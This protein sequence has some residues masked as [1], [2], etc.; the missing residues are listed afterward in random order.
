[1]KLNIITITVFT[2]SLMLGC[3][4]DKNKSDAYGNFEATETLIS[5]EVAG[6]IIKLD[7]EEGKMI[8]AGEVIAIIDTTQLYLKRQQLEAQRNAISAKTGNIAGQIKVYDEQK[9]NLLK[10]K[11][12]IEKMLKDG[13]ATQKQMDDVNGGIMVIE[14]QIESVKT[15]NPA[16]FGEIE[17]LN[18]QIEQIKDQIV[19]SSIKNPFDGT[20]LEKYVEPYEITAIGKAV[21][22]VAN[23]SVMTLKVYVDGS[24]L[25]GIKLNQTV[26]VLIDK[27]KAEN[28]SLTGT[29]SWISSQAE[30]TPKI[31]QTKKERVNMVYAVKVLVKNPDGTIKIGM[32]GEV[33][34]N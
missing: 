12:R 9:L 10:D 32:P 27:D 6:K 22:K 18:K 5:S 26:K 21:Y 14:R 15:Q 33:I 17:S 20:V 23:L 4:G 7:I 25:P 16:V 11:L 30:F 28:Q 2:L 29:I 8:K 19:R 24:Q 13:A 34:F 3:N 31:I 1:M